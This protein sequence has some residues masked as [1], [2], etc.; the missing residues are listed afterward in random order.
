[1]VDETFDYDANGNRLLRDGQVTNSVFD[2]ANRRLE[3]EDFTYIYDANG[4]LETKTDKFTSA[5][6]TSE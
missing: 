2:A 5:V 6:T 1:M 4:N 3:D